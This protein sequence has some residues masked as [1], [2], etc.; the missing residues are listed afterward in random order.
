MQLC[1]SVP[2]TLRPDGGSCSPSLNP[3]RKTCQ[4]I[5]SPITPLVV[6]ARRTRIGCSKKMVGIGAL[7]TDRMKFSVFP[8]QF[9][10]HHSSGACHIQRVLEAEHRNTHVRV[11]NFQKP[12]RESV[13]FMPKQHAYRKVRTPVKQI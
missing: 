13:H 5:R 8:E 1:F 3:G 7:S 4:S 2:T 10:H 6:R 12:G 9:V 11:A